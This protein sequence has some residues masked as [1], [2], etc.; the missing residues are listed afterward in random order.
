[1]FKGARVWRG[2]AGLEAGLLKRV[3]DDLSEILSAQRLPIAPVG[4]NWILVG[5]VSCIDV[6][7]HPIH[8]G[9]RAIFFARE[10]KCNGYN[11]P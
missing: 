5:R 8:L 9:A 2:Q 11:G 10:L 4:R 3:T 1:M 6:V 7:K